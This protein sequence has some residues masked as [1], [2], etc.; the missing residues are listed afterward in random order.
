MKVTYDKTGDA[1][2]IYLADEIAPGGVAKTYPCDPLEVN[3]MINL[4]FDGEGRI[5]GI[6]VIDASKKL[7]PEILKNALP[8]GEN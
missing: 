3:G 6:E 8:P 1:A 2:Y 4:D 5:V 7:P